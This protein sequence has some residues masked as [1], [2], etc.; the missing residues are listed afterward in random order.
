MELTWKEQLDRVSNLSPELKE[1]IDAFERDI[2]LR[3]QGKVDERLFA[4]TRLRRG[5]YGQR[6][7]N[8]QRHDGKVPRT[9]PYE[10]K[11]SKGP[12]TVWDAPG[13]QRIKIPYGH[14]TSTQMVTLAE[15][16][17]DYA[18]GVLHVTTRQDIQLHFVHID[19]TPD[20]M[21]RLGAAG[22]TTQEACGNTVRN[23]TACPTAGVCSTESFD[24]TPYADALAS[25]LL[26]HPDAQDFG[27]KFKV[28]FSGCAGEAC[29]LAYMH[30]LGFIAK[31]EIV[32][33]VTRRGFT[34]LVGGGLGAVPQKAELFDSFLPEEELL[35]MSQAACRVFARFGERKN[36]GKARLKHLVIKMGL[37]PFKAA[38]LEER[39]RLPHDPR[40]TAYLDDRV[41]TSSERAPADATG[42]RSGASSDLVTIGQTGAA[43]S[44]F[45]RWCR[46]NVRAQ[47]QV[48][49]SVATIALPLGDLTSDQ[50]RE[51]A[52]IATRFAGGSVRATVEQN[53]VLRWVKDAEL[54]AV[55]AAL[56]AAGLAERGAGTIADITAC[57]GTDTCKLG[58]ASSRGLASALHARF[59]AR[60]DEL[61][62]SV[63]ALRIKASG[64]FNSCG[65]HHVADI[66][67][68]GSSRKRGAHAVPHFQV[69]LGGQWSENAGS[70]GLAV[71][72]VPSKRIPEVVDRVT[73]AYVSDRTENE[74]FQAFIRRVGKARVRQMLEDLTEVPGYEVA[75]EFYSDWGDPRV[76]S[77]SDYGVGEC[78]GAVVPV[79]EFGLH[80]SER[81]VFE[82][83]LQLEAAAYGGAARVAYEAMMTAARALVERET[84]HAVTDDD[85]VVQEF[86]A[87]L[88]DT[89]RFHDPY[90]GGRF[91]LF[92]FHAHEGRADAIGE[93]EAHRRVEEAQLF[94]EAAHAFYERTLKEASSR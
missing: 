31:T 66:G 19:D 65:Q 48:G 2:A 63:S 36:R 73:A 18:D 89:K 51:L 24:V 90:A 1:Q 58:I 39:A 78:A 21:R 69:V 8:G 49:Y 88:Y 64:C 11:A 15:V 82:A 79:V 12:N 26:G 71:G 53:I 80:A 44:A 38:V 25:F 70:F 72:A 34:F 60:E 54:A 16:A 17:E 47:R 74:S 6:Y 41:D 14:M 33:G 67:F 84:S 92:L 37:E 35:P 4:E 93:Q 62:P 50:M 91:A 81:K 75:P 83:Q 55:Y 45:E 42:S 76:Y 29:G 94:I 61:D 43:T 13:M 46:S 27:R 52:I 32:D 68:Y 77:M 10:E 85:V 30:D 59:V 7:D 86:R 56:E 87:R 23:I 9:L 22:I 57:P 28:A 40:W 5:A 20:L 3:K